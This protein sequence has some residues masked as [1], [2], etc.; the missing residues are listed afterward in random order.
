MTHEHLR[1]LGMEETCSKVSYVQKGTF[2][3]LKNIHM[4]PCEV[5][6]SGYLGSSGKNEK[7]MGLGI[8]ETNLL[9]WAVSQVPFVLMRSQ[10]GGNS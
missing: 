3:G 2:H 9:A 1:I 5:E 8:E 10:A 7:V 6:T 4:A